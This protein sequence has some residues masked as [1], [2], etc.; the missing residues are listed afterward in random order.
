[1]LISGKI[2]TQLGALFWINI[3]GDHKMAKKKGR[4]HAPSQLTLNMLFA[5]AAGRCQFEG[6]NKSVLFDELTLKTYNKSNVAHIIAS[7]PGGA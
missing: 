4:G 1:M 7:S 5:N 6:C 2:T 3:G